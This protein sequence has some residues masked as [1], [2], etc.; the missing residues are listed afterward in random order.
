MA[1]IDMVTMASTGFQLRL[2]FPITSISGCGDH[3]VFIHTGTF[4]HKMYAAIAEVL[5]PSLLE[6]IV[7]PH[8]ESDECG[9][10]DRFIAD[11]PKA[12]LICSEAGAVINPPAGT[13]SVPCGAFGMAM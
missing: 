8:F 6:Y 3:P 1:R 10:M 11:A 12:T 4:P 5:D 9:G 2:G 13:T 7:V